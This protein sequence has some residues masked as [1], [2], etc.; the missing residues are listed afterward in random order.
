[1]EES[2]LDRI[3]KKVDRILELLENQVLSTDDNQIYT[4][5]VGKLTDEMLKR[6]ELGSYANKRTPGTVSV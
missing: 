3:E 1:M 6:F 2:Q 4:L 5:E